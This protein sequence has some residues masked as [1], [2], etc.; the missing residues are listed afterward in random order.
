MPHSAFSRYVRAV[1]IAL[2]LCAPYLA[3]PAKTYATWQDNYECYTTFTCSGA[4]LTGSC[5]PHGM[6]CADDHS[7]QTYT[8]NPVWGQ[9]QIVR[10]NS[11]SWVTTVNCVPNP[12]K[13]CEITA[14]QPW[15]ASDCD[16]YCK[17]VFYNMCACTCINYPGQGAETGND[18]TCHEVCKVP[19]PP[20]P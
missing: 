8:T 1:S 5:T 12:T 7:C 6:L 15:I 18:P 20:A 2:A 13:K 14:P 4:S 3:T 17:L 10:P 19:P 16:A 9:G 11:C